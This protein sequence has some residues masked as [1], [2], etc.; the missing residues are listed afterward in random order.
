MWTKI[1]RGVITLQ[2]F[3]HGSIHWLNIYTQCLEG[4]ASPHIVQYWNTKQTQVDCVKKELSMRSS[5]QSQRHIKN[6]WAPGIMEKGGVAI[7]DYGFVYLQK[8]TSGSIWGYPEF[9]WKVTNH[10]FDF[11]LCFYSRCVNRMYIKD[12]KMTKRKLKWESDNI[13]VVPIKKINESWSCKDLNTYGC[14]VKL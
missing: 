9:E 6:I 2:Q 14:N 1:E 11:I 3:L 7:L 13:V 4:G 5:A 12:S 10:K 8:W